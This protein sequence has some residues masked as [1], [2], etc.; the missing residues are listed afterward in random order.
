MARF[1]QTMIKKVQMMNPP[2]RT[3]IYNQKCNQIV[4]IRVIP[5][6][7][8]ASDRVHPKQNI[9]KSIKPQNHTLKTLCL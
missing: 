9:Q 1:Y 4:L 7:I 5:D 2:Q 3:L 8:L 6:S